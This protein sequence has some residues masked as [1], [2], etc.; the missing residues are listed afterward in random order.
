MIEEYKKKREREG[1]VSPG[2]EENANP[3][4]W[5]HNTVEGGGGEDGY[6]PSTTAM[7]VQNDM[8]DQLEMAISAATSEVDGQNKRKRK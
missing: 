8:V 1:Y 2:E 5:K 3:A 6:D 7:A 4:V